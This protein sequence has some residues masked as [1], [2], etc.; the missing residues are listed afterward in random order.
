MLSTTTYDK[1]Y[2]EGVLYVQRR[3]SLPHFA[4]YVG[5]FN[6]NDQGE[7]SID[8]LD[9]GASRSQEGCDGLHGEIQEVGPEARLE[10]FS[11][12]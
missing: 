6:T 12:H 7:H 1:K 2:G 5:S 4:L 8:H 3:C 9:C 11:L 10:L